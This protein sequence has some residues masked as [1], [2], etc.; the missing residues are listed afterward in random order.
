MAATVINFLGWPV[1]SRRE[2]NIVFRDST[3]WTTDLPN[4]VAPDD[5]T[6]TSIGA[7][8]AHEF[9]HLL[10]F[11]HDDVYDAPACM[12]SEYPGGCDISGSLRISETDFVDLEAEKGDSS[13]GSNLMVSKFVRDTYNQPREV[14]T[15]VEGAYGQSVEV[16][17]VCPGETLTGFQRPAAIYVHLTG[18]TSLSNVEVQWSLSSDGVCD[19]ADD[20]IIRTKTIGSL[21]VNTAYGVQPDPWTVPVDTPPGTYFLCATVDPNNPTD[22]FAETRS[23]DNSVRSDRNFF[24]RSPLTHEYCDGAWTPEP[25]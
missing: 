4:Q 3:D 22:D 20:V 23:G 5:F 17:D 16:W 8:A 2:T 9:G 11:A 21:A 13:T 14:W 25:I 6:T 12:H 7:V 15:D 18:S 1:C 19:D 24:V 10:G